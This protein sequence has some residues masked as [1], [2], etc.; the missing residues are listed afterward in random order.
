MDFDSSVQEGQMTLDSC[1]HGHL[2]P[3]PECR[4]ALDVGEEEGD[5]AGGQIRHDSR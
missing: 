4:A 5:G 3:L 2:V 1:R